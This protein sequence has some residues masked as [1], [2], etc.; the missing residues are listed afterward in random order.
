MKTT[1][2]ADFLSQAGTPAL[3]GPTRRD[4]NGRVFALRARGPNAIVQLRGEGARKGLIDRVD[5]DGLLFVWFGAVRAPLYWSNTVYRENFRRAAE[6]RLAE[7]RQDE[8]FAQGEE[9]GALPPPWEE[10]DPVVP[11][12]EVEARKAKG[13]E[14]VFVEADGSRVVEQVSV[15]DV[16]IDDAELEAGLK[17]FD[18]WEAE[19]VALSM[20][21]SATA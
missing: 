17:A 5:R 2:V 6:Y 15:F 16:E 21:R 8:A 12:V 14:I 7:R 13:E 19:R 10:V 20:K 4:T 11:A 9:V 3:E 18:D 1:I